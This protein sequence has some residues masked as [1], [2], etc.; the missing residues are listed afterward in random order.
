MRAVFSGGQTIGRLGAE[1]AVAVVP[2]TRDL[3]CSV[4]LLREILDELDLGD[5]ELRV[6]IEGLP[7]SAEAVPQLL[8]ELARPH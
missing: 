1:R 6:W 7:G 2:R 8:D 5:A 4:A 3:G